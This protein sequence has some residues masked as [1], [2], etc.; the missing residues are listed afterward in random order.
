MSHKRRGRQQTRVRNLERGQ[1][2]LLDHAVEDNP[3]H[4]LQLLWGVFLAGAR[5]FEPV[6]C[7]GV[8]PRFQCEWGL[9]ALYVGDGQIGQYLQ[10]DG[11]GAKTTN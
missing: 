3:R 6:P 10:V 7:A 5:C 2:P 9:V 1:G 11:Q 4:Q 8:L